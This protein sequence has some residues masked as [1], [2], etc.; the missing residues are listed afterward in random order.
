MSTLDTTLDSTLVDVSDFVDRNDLGFM[1]GQAVFCI[2]DGVKRTDA[3]KVEEAIPW[4]KRAIIIAKQG[5]ENADRYAKPAEVPVEADRSPSS[6]APALPH[7]RKPESHGSAM[8]NPATK[9]FTCTQCGKTKGCTAFPRGA[10]DHEAAAICHLCLKKPS[11]SDH[12]DKGKKNGVKRECIACGKR[13]PIEEFQK[14]SW[15]CRDCDEEN[16]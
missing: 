1:L 10:A 7:K 9:T 15:V 4:I 2:V 16:A 12:K 11:A 6:E 8:A 5:G 3:D 14:G 13:K